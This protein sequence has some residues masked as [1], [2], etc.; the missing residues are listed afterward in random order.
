MTHKTDILNRLRCSA[1]LILIP[2]SKIV[3][4]FSLKHLADSGFDAPHATKIPRIDPFDCGYLVI[5][6]RCPRSRCQS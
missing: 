2:N 6:A 1:I 5:F 3:V 4:S